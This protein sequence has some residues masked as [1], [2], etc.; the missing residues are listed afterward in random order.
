M[1]GT[2]TWRQDLLTVV[3]WKEINLQSWRLLLL[4]IFLEVITG[5][6]SNV[7]FLLERCITKAMCWGIVCRR[8]FHQSQGNDFKV[9]VQLQRRNS[10]IILNCLNLVFRKLIGPYIQHILDPI[11]ILLPQMDFLKDMILVVRLITLLGG[12]VVFTNPQL[13]SSH[14][15]I[16][17]L[18][19]WEHSLRQNN[20]S[21]SSSFNHIHFSGNLSSNCNNFYSTILGNHELCSIKFSKKKWYKANHHCN[22]VDSLF[23]IVF[24]LPALYGFVLGV[25]ASTVTQWPN[26]HQS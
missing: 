25:E 17:Q 19:H 4:N 10:C 20:S 16:F 15:S 22:H 6:L 18:R 12:I 8:S 11:S 26:L 24:L 7:Y 9:F 2:L 21:F 3:A 5:Y 13:F 1:M 23:S 14:V